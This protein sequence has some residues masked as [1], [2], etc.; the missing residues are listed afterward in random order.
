M[1]TLIIHNTIINDKKQLY[2]N[3]YFSDIAIE[4]E[5]HECSCSQRNT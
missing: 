4:L 5:S 2:F 1:T 3:D